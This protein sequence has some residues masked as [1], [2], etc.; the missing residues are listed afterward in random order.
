MPLAESCS[1]AACT[2]SALRLVRMTEAPRWPRA[3]ATA[4]PMPRLAPVTRARRPVRLKTSVILF[5][6]L[7][8][9]R[10]FPDRVEPTSLHQLRRGPRQRQQHRTVAAV[11][12]QERAGAAGGLGELFA[13]QL[14]E[15][16]FR[17]AKERLALGRRTC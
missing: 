14:V 1:V 11:A 17:I 6:V 3:R 10:R 2:A 7:S 13:F 5:P 12:H 8:L 16:R 4:R 9:S 15:G